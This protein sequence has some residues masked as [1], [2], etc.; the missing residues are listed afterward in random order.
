[1]SVL[2]AQLTERVR[3][4]KSARD[5][6]TYL[7]VPEGDVVSLSVGDPD[8]PPPPHVIR[9]AHEAL[10][11]GRTRYTHWQ[12]LRE[13]R[14]AIADK[15]GRE[16]G[17]DYTPDETIVT[18]GAEEALFI[19]LMGL[20]GPGD[21]VLFADPYFHAVPKLVRLTGG[22]PVFVPVRE[23]DRFVL[24][25]DEVE[26]R[27]TPRAKALI[28]ITPNNP[29]GA[30][31]DP[32]ALEALAD[33][34][35]RRN[36][37]VISDEIYER[38]LYDGAQH[39]SIAGL[40][41]MR[42]RTVVTN[43]FSKAYSMTGFRLGYLAGPSDLIEGLQG[44]KEPL[45]IC[46]SS[47]SQWAGLAALTGPQDA[48]ERIRIYD[49][50]RRV[51][52]AGLDAMAIPYVRP[53]GGF[54]LLANISTLGL[55]SLEFCRRMLDNAR[56]TL[57]PGALTASGDGYVRISWLLPVDRIREGLGRMQRF[58]EGLRAATR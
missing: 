45:S 54:F 2:A 30:V 32:E 57:F 40:P 11:A 44:L 24:R 28:V 1:M 49:E 52:M 17:L 4:Q 48:A 55:G 3:A 16:N 36:L 27:I 23:V 26:R 5:S 7:I 53:R 31:L 21:E 29:T 38:I 12:G 15:L 14:E 10:D 56:V 22:T 39:Y 34:A 25:A 41:G 6:D 20:V 35:R 19:A 9:A 46:A 42:E 43:G 33:V 13:L 37:V 47:I 51:L 50:R 58:V 18:V 8:L